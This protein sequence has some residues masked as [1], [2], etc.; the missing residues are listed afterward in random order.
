M[1]A[2]DIRARAAASLIRRGGEDWS[3]TDQAE[4]EYWLAES[5]AN[6]VAY[7]RA[8][9]VWK[10]AN[11]LGAL[12]VAATDNAGDSARRV[13][14]RGGRVVV[15]LAIAV[16]L[17]AGSAFYYLSPRETIYSTSLG[18]H[19]TIVLADGSKIE[20]NTDTVLRTTIS[21]QE[22]VVSLDRGEAYFEVK[23]DVARPFIVM[24][25]DHRVTDLGTK[26]LARREMSRLR[27]AVVEG[28][29]RLDAVGGHGQP[30]ATLMQGDVAVATTNGM[31]MVKKP[32]LQLT[33]ELSWRHGMLVFDNTMLGDA[34][35]EFNRYNREK[36]VVV[37]AEAARMKIDGKFRTND[38]VLFARAAR[39]LLGLRAEG[40][41]DELVIS[42]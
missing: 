21:N 3:E 29:V 26:F 42:R 40:R 24:A 12:R 2:K 17:G 28:R 37:G 14:R 35:A 7:L 23:H 1:S 16:A 19:K 38:V 18:G 34:A 41:G 22:R 11:R 30:A 15:A 33:S 6:M 27:V 20:L 32:I 5:P 25:G 36:L 8:D 13:W 31:S 39:I 10:R 9:A 4:L